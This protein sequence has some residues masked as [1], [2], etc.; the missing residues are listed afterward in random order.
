MTDRKS[1]LRFNL[2]LILIF[3]FSS[4]VFAG[5]INLAGVGAK[6]L[7]M[8]GAF[9][10][11]SDDWSAMYWNPA[12]LGGQGTA[13]SL[14]AKGLFPMTWITPNAP[15]LS[16]TYDDYRLYR[17]GVKQSSNEALYPAGAFGFTY[18]I[19]PEVTVG[20]SVFFPS[21]LGTEWEG[22]YTAPY[23]G[24]G[25]NPDYPDIA[26]SSDLMVMDIHPTV[27]WK[28]EENVKVGLGI[29][30]RYAT[31][32]LVSPAIVPS[33]DGTGARLPFPAQH[34]FIDGILDGH[35]FGFGYNL[36]VLVSSPD[37]PLS[38]GMSFTSPVNIPIEGTVTQTLYLPRIAGGGT[39]VAEPDAEADLPLPMDFGVGLAYDFSPQLTIAAD[40]VWTKWEDMD[41]LQIKL[42]GDGLADTDGDGVID[43]ADDTELILNWEDTFRFNVGMNYKFL[44]VEGLET[45]IGY[46]FDPTPIP[47][48]T[49][50]PSI[51][52]VADKHNVSFGAA[53]S[54][55]KF[56]FEA[57]WEH[58]FTGDRTAEAT[59]NDHDGVFD[60]VPGDWR[61]QVDTFGMQVSYRF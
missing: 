44:Q 22:L 60:N 46:Y 45:R 6:A 30:I 8:S 2:I 29:A 13:I 15:A 1:S 9:R 37:N 49:I 18:Q 10:A 43:P 32:N 38:I 21:A 26:W 16:T 55:N 53:Y 57:Y 34:F 14:E 11:I 50:R 41:V 47:T 5:G 4:G 59:D 23:A 20:L 25:E 58:L 51:T 28:M 61:M 3:A 35:G 12:G 31:I 40:V 52:D 42:F 27:G 56:I 33:N 7:S 36:G 19:N 54:V 48:E 39:V 17:N 24:Y